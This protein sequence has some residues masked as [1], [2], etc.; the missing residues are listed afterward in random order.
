M[1]VFCFSRPRR[2]TAAAFIKR[3]GCGTNKVKTHGDGPNGIGKDSCPSAVLTPLKHLDTLDL[4]CVLLPL[5][6]YKST[7]G[8]HLFTR[9]LAHVGVPGKQDYFFSPLTNKSVSDSRYIHVKKL[10]T[11]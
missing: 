6:H 11:R 5:N 2:L 3:S 7:P 8:E 10:D 9:A 1:L 4:Y